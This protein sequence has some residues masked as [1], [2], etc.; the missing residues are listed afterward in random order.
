MSDTLRIVAFD[1]GTNKIVGAVSE[2][3]A[4]ERLSIIAIEE[5]KTL[6]GSMYRGRINNV[7]DVLFHIMSI[8]KKLQNIFHFQ[9]RKAMIPKSGKNWKKKW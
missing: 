4:D 5:E 7:N 3:T 2:K 6:N 8:I 9:T 1:I